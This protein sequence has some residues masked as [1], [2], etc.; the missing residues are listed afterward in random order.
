MSDRR[1]ITNSYL[2]KEENVRAAL[3][4][5]YPNFPVCIEGFLKRADDDLLVKAAGLSE[6]LLEG[7]IGDS[8]RELLSHELSELVFPKL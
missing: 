8:V 2:I 6:A 7:Q 5:I 3:N 4:S 1:I